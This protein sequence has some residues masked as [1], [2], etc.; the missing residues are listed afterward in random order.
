MGR[1]VWH[2]VPFYVGEGH[3]GRLLWGGACLLAR[4]AA[5]LAAKDAGEIGFAGFFAMKLQSVADVIKVAG[6]AGCSFVGVAAG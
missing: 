4:L 6:H 1:G 3:K 5:G 2:L